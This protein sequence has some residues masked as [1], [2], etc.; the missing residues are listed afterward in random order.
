MA[1]EHGK[2]WIIKIPVGEVLESLYISEKEN[3]YCLGSICVS[4]QLGAEE[5]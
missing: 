2:V 1:V 4:H 3:M 5:D